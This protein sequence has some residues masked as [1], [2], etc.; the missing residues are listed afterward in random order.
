MKNLMY[1]ALM[2]VMVSG[3]YGQVVVNEV[4][5][6]PI[7]S[8]ED[9]D[10]FIE[11]YNN[12]GSS[13]DLSGWTFTDGDAN[14][15]IIAWNE[16]VHGDIS[17]ADP[18][19][20]TTNLPS[21]SYAVI[22]DQEYESGT[23]PYDFPAGTIILTTSNTTLGDGLETSD[24]VELLNGSSV[25]ISTY[26]SPANGSDGLPFNPG[27]G[28][29]AE[30]KHSSIP[31]VEGNWE[32][33]ANIGGTPGDQNSVYDSSLPVELSSFSAQHND[34][35]VEIQWTTQSELNNSGFYILRSENDEANFQKISHL[36]EGAGSSSEK[37]NY[38]FRDER[39]DPNR[40][41]FYQLQQVD[42]DGTIESFGPVKVVIQ[43]EE[44]SFLEI[45][46]KSKLV[47]NYP[48]PFNPGTTLF[49]S[50][51]E[52]EDVVV[53]VYDIIGRKINTLFSG[54]I[55]A[56]NHEMGWD[57]LDQNGMQAPSGHYFVKMQTASGKI[58]ALK[59]LKIQ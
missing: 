36:I 11:L 29:S 22:L 37:H 12:S 51:E 30:K 7:A 57:G 3:L 55:D 26:G 32:K 14:D 56:G 25:I 9:F 45:P 21:N 40:T 47:G 28:Y 17:D 1:L 38:S 5:S 53:S 52:S 13:V 43:S 2:F 20:N 15:N 8:D 42:M 58:S 6:N 18:T 16:S 39:V 46:E 44:E 19:F 59:V 27:N 4:M 34:N 31:D 41:Y 48:N 49:L 54:I 24:P 33:S 23:Q 35:H 50:L 10:E